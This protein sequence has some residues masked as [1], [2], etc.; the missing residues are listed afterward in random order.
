MQEATMQKAAMQEAYE[1]GG[2]RCGDAGGLWRGKLEM[3][4]AHNAERM[5]GTIEQR[6]VDGLARA[7]RR[8]KNRKLRCSVPD[9]DLDL[10]GTFLTVDE[11]SSLTAR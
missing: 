10:S 7:C 6:L 3:R 11:P 5:Q 8:N 2:L 4:N 9:D 1:A